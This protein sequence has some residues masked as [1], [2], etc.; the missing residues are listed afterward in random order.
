MQF[1]SLSTVCERHVH[2]RVYVWGNVS[3]WIFLLQLCPTTGRH[4]RVWMCVCVVSDSAPVLDEL[5]EKEARMHM[6][7]LTVLSNVTAAV[8]TSGRFVFEA[9]TRS[10][11]RRVIQTVDLRGRRQHRVRSLQEFYRNIFSQITAFFALNVGQQFSLL[12]VFFFFLSPAC[13]EHSGI[14]GHGSHVPYSRLCPR[15]GCLWKHA[16]DPKIWTQSGFYAVQTEVYS[17]C[18]MFL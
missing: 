2:D 1:E 11:E 15:K 4:K 6:K 16:A 9:V 5:E 10:R 13:G 14:L 12:E 18:S 17:P 8:S 7:A 3:V